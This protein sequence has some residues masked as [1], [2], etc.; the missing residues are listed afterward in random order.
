[1]TAKLRDVLLGPR[2]LLRGFRLVTRT[3]RLLFLGTLP[4]LLTTLLLLAAVIT[5]LVF[6]GDIASW[7]TPFADDWSAD[8]RAVLRFIV[9]AAL[10]GGALMIGVIIFAVLTLAIGAPFYERIAAYVD[11]RLGMGPQSGIEPPGNPVLDWLRPL[12]TA[13]VAGLV[14][15]VV[16]LVPFL[17]TTVAVVSSALI[18]GSLLATEL[19]ETAFAARGLGYDQRRA[20]LRRRPMLA[21][22]F[23]VPVYLLCLVPFLAVII[24]PA[25]VAGGT[26][27]ARELLG[28]PTE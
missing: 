14:L 7:L 22:G 28:E 19:I 4:A 23:G 27:L 1:M 10:V 11:K 24:M 26:L 8:A 18:G 20:A 2:L 5:L 12:V 25:A 6:V 9:G 3:P 13:L 15:F 17:G 16:A 21:L